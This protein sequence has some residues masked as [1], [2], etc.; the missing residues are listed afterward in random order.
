MS[1]SAPD[2][3]ESQGERSHV[4][5]VRKVGQRL[6]KTRAA[7]LDDISHQP[8]QFI[9]RTWTGLQSDVKRCGIHSEIA[10]ISSHGARSWKAAVP[11]PLAA[12]RGLATAA[13]P[14]QR[15]IECIQVI[16][17]ED[18]TA[19]FDHVSFETDRSSKVLSW[20]STSS[21]AWLAHCQ[22]GVHWSLRL[23]RLL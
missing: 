9:K 4:S 2:S 16:R 13:P 18:R 7:G 8:A 6:A 11:Y 5:K 20:L 10:W 23:C 1:Q 15:K 14:C 19:S 17:K 21:D 22:T 12:S 3:D